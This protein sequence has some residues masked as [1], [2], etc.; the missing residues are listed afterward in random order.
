MT[1]VSQIIT[2]A[3]QYNNLIALSAIPTAAE[4]DKALRYLNRLFRSVFGNELG[5]KFQTIYLGDIDSL[6]RDYSDT[7]ETLTSPF[8]VYPSVKLACLL[9][10]ASTVYLTPT[11]QDGAR[12]SIQDVI[13]NFATYPLTV[14]ANGRLIEEA[15][16]KTLN[17]NGLN[18]EWFY[19]GDLSNWVKV[20]DLTLTDTF[21]LPQEFEEMFILLLSLRLS[22]SDDVEFNGQLTYVLNNT[23]KK[24]RS[25]YRQNVEVNSE[26]A[27]IRLT[28]NRYYQDLTTRFNYG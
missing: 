27:L 16:T 28:N 23:M 26:P 9:T 8:V 12:V 10:S 21:P 18:S 5:E 2:D 15:P 7:I 4:Q 19:R 14:I 11:P 3:Y 1:T 6:V 24:F 13:G 25:R 20:T 22:A 17:I